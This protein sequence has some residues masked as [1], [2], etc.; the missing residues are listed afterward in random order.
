M[1]RKHSGFASQSYFCYDKSNQN[2][3]LDKWFRT[4]KSN[5]I[6]SDELI[7]V[8]TS[9]CRSDKNNHRSLPLFSV[10]RTAIPTEWAH[11]V[12]FRKAVQE[13]RCLCSLNAQIFC[14]V[15]KCLRHFHTLPQVPPLR[16]SLPAL[17]AFQIGSTVSSVLSFKHIKIIWVKIN[18]SINPKP[19]RLSLPLPRGNLYDS[20]HFEV[21]KEWLCET[22]VLNGM[23]KTSTLNYYGSG[24]SP[25]SLRRRSPRK[26]FS[27]A[28]G[29]FVYFADRGK[30]K[31]WAAWAERTLMFRTGHDNNAG[32]RGRR[33]LHEPHCH[34]E[35]SEKPF[36]FSGRAMLA[37]TMFTVRLRLIADTARHV[38]TKMYLF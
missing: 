20:Y 30:V 19:Y 12:L 32:Y 36:Y 13:N 37:P 27:E 10:L 28:K 11:R 31:A 17:C 18:I 16:Q 24:L 29:R 4:Q 25:P 6:R 35:R 3:S 34:S 23:W 22:V 15:W 1:Y 5:G 8:I 9:V 26:V 21:L 7:T 33:P 14:L 38:P 2:H